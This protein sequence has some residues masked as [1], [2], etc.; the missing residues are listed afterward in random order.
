MRVFEAIA[1]RL[2]QS[3]DMMRSTGVDLSGAGLAVENRL[4]NAQWRC[5]FCRHG[6][7]CRTWIEAGTGSVP[8]YC[9]NRDFYR[10][11]ARRKPA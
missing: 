10:A 5:L 11:H 4:R 9:P 2:D 3:G 1:N 6:D 7:E 8:D